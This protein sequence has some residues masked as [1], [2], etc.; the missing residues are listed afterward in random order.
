[1]QREAPLQ[2]TQCVNGGDLYQHLQQIN[3][4]EMHIVLCAV[5]NL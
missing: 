5:N 3:K 1:M 4:A 2:V